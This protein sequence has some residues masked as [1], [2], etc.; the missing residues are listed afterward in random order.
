MLK[1]QV[2]IKMKKILNLLDE[3]GIFVLNFTDKVDKIKK[4]TI[5]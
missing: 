2:L 5:L 4:H 1:H 3:V